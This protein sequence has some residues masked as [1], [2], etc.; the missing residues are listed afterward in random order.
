M[1]KTQIQL[2]D[3]VYARLKALAARLEVSLAEL[4]RRG[5][6]YVLSVYPSEV[7][8]STEWRLPEPLDLGE[9]LVAVE[10][11]REYACEQPPEDVLPS[12]H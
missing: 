3:E 8:A 11:W 7:A 10:S 5:A 4:L 6:D 12:R 1:A 9:P 2:P